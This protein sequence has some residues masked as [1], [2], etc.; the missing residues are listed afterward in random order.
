MNK[1]KL[2]TVT[3]VMGYPKVVSSIFLIQTLSYE[4]ILLVKIMTLG[5]DEYYLII[6]HLLL[7]NIHSLF[8]ADSIDNNYDVLVL[9]R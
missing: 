6:C 1:N 9:L 3:K 4:K 8:F 2:L 7:I 5:K